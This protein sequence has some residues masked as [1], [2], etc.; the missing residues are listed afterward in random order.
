MGFWCLLAAKLLISVD[1]SLV[2][3]AALDIVSNADAIAIDQVCGSVQSTMSVAW[4]CIEGAFPR[5]T[6]LARSERLTQTP[7]VV[8]VGCVC[9]WGGGVYALSGHLFPP[10]LFLHI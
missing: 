2:V 9:V 6:V 1:P 7:I 8:V 3:G 4:R 5:S 10:P